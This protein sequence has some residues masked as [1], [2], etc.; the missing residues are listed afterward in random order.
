ME[1]VDK[2]A[3]AD[4]SEIDKLSEMFQVELPLDFIE[5]WQHSDGSNVF[6]GFKELQFFSVNEILGEDIYEINK[7]M[8]SSMPVCL[9]GN[10]NICVARI[11][12]GKIF[13]FY[14]ASCGDLG[15]DDSKL[16][17]NTF[18]NFISDKVSPEERLN[19]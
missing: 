12:A 10:G 1:Y 13:G 18:S 9:D 3:G 5:W 6:W 14:V 8:P 17:A 4:I 7:Y 19:A 16:I 2:P 11:E 15:W